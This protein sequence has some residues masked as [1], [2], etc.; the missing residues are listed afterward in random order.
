MNS[1][2]YLGREGDT[3][4]SGGKRQSPKIIVCTALSLFDVQ[5]AWMEMG[6]SFPLFLAWWYLRVPNITLQLFIGSQSVSERRKGPKS[7]R[8]TCSQF[9]NTR[10]RI[11]LTK[12]LIAMLNLCILLSNQRICLKLSKQQMISVHPMT[13][14][15]SMG[16][17]LASERMRV[18]NFE[19][20][21][22]CCVP[23]PSLSSP[24]SIGTFRRGEKRVRR[25]ERPKSDE[26]ETDQET[27]IYLSG[28]VRRE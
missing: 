21:E 14:K 27:I 15:R 7:R 17:K 6:F 4:A 3:H 2:F 1:I 25:Q 13:R 16:R 12:F 28:R 26:E 22:A 24:R 5:C 11:K 20:T 23:A 8:R 9:E 18:G 19:G 10:T